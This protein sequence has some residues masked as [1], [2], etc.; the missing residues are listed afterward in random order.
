[1]FR[2]P[3]L[4]W[5]RGE[6]SGGRIEY[7]ENLVLSGSE[8]SALSGRNKAENWWPYLEPFFTS[9]AHKG[10]GAG[11]GKPQTWVVT[12][13]LHLTPKVQANI[14]PKALGSGTNDEVTDTSSVVIALICS[15]DVEVKGGSIFFKGI[16]KQHL[17]EELQSI[18]ISEED[19]GKKMVFF[20]QQPKPTQVRE[21]L[22]G[23]ASKFPHCS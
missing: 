6:C 1:M 20:S 22:S 13:G 3:Y 14:I 23:S 19:M 21:K 4:L 8:V 18:V 16:L 11:T 15:V 12:C 17:Y 9:E 10:K 2:K 5:V 7:S